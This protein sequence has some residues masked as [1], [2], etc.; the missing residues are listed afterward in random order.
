M[1]IKFAVMIGMSQAGECFMEKK[2]IARAT[3]FR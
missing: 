1:S 3:F 2:K